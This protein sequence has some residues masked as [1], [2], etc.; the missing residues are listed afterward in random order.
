M[1]EEVPV[2]RKALEIVKGILSLRN[3]KN[4]HIDVPEPARYRWS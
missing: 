4:T 2:W 3:L 1:E